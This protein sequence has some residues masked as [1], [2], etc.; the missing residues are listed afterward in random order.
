VTSG[1]TNGDEHAE[2]EA[3]L[4]LLRSAKEE[5]AE[6]E[7][8]TIFDAHTA[9]VVELALDA[10]ATALQTLL[11]DDLSIVGKRVPDDAFYEWLVENGVLDSEA[12]NAL[13]ILL[14][15]AKDARYGEEPDDPDAVEEARQ[16]FLDGLRPLLEKVGVA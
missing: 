1:P 15:A 11:N 8:T 5:F 2:D 14:E 13:D 4:A 7:S 12:G 16:Q 9:R 6:L 10:L 3:Y